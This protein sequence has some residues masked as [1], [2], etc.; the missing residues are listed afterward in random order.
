MSW[1]S[2]VI[3]E[4]MASCDYR[5][6]NILGI[7]QEKNKAVTAILDVLPFDESNMLR[8]LNCVCD[9]R[10]SFQDVKKQLETDNTFSHIHLFND[11]DTPDISYAYHVL[12]YTPETQ[13][14]SL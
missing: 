10:I 13:R 4:R 14:T 6:L 7:F 5:Y 1:I 9:K 11:E 8:Y 12:E 3:D 2:V